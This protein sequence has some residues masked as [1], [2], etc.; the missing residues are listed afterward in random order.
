MKFIYFFLTQINLVSTN[1][2]Y[3]D[4][5]RDLNFLYILQYP[6]TFHSLITSIFFYIRVLFIAIHCFQLLCSINTTTTVQLISSPPHNESYAILN[7]I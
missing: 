4:V 2:F 7:V 6:K 3:F 1:Q 5:V